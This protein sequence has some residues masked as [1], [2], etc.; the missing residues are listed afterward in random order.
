MFVVGKRALFF[1]AIAPVL[2]GSIPLDAGADLL[3][4]ARA[5][6][7]PSASLVLNAY[8]LA[9]VRPGAESK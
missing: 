3:Q 8:W 9:P 2:I 1:L 6:K 7:A 5:F 4:R